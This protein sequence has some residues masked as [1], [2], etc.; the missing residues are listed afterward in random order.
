MLIK[1]PNFWRTKPSI[2]SIVLL[3]FAYIYK[4]VAGVVS[5]FRKPFKAPVPI[6]CVGNHV[7]GGAGKTPVVQALA[8]YLIQNGQHPHIV[9]RGYGGKKT[10]SPHKV[11]PSRD[12]AEIVGDEPL[13]L[14]EI[15]PTWVCKNKRLA[16]LAAYETGATHVILDD[17]LQSNYFKDTY[18]ILV[19]DPPY[20]FNNPLPFPAGPN[21]ESF[22][23]ATDKSQLTVSYSDYGDDIK[24]NLSIQTEL[25]FK[26][27]DVIGFAGI[28]RPDKFK[29]SLQFHGCNIIDFQ[30]FPDHHL[31]TQNEITKLVNTAKAKKATL[32]TTK[33]DFVRIP[34]SQR[35]YVKVM[36]LRVHEIEAQEKLA[37]LLSLA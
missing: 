2:L 1:T 37:D 13:L 8:E 4:M 36:T 10:K 11:N 3:P 32:V 28:G 29:Q 34:Q 31:F 14:A 6:I 9:S 15:A 30:A 27:C 7:V 20:G 21:R 35:K 16:M 22:A 24:K 12:K 25:G 17:G 5:M 26:P 19:I 18:N 33:K 23:A